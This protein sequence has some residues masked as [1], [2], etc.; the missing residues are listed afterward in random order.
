[1]IAGQSSIVGRIDPPSDTPLDGVLWPDA[2]YRSGIIV[3]C[4]LGSSIITDLTG[5]YGVRSTCGGA[6]PAAVTGEAGEAPEEDT[7]PAVAVAESALA[8]GDKSLSL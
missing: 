7:V 2:L 8:C 3:F 6:A 4:C 5:S 1:M